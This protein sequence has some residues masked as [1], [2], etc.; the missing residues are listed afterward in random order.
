MMKNTKMFHVKHSRKLHRKN[1]QKIECLYNEYISTLY[2]DYMGSIGENVSRET[3]NHQY[4]VNLN[5][6]S[7]LNRK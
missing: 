5:R 1:T 4:Q 7:N 2:S 6:K 3:I